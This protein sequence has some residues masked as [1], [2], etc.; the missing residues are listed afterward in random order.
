VDR[1]ALVAFWESFRQ[2]CGVDAGDYD[3]FAFGDSAEMADELARLVAD[4]PK[5]ATAG[6]LLDYERDQEP[7][8]R[9]GALSVVLDGRGAPV[10]VIRTTQVEVKPLHQVDEAFAWDE[11]EGDRT[12]AWWLDA[13]RRFFRRRCADLGVPFSDDLPTVFERF[14]LVWP[15]QRVGESKHQGDG[16]RP[17]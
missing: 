11:G 5:R 4:G 8:P 6:L 15:R 7:V 14:E 3:T 2:A 9:P 1:A 17:G 12:L 13:H 16:P 10:C